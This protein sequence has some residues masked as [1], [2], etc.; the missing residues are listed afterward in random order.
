MDFLDYF[1][2][3]SYFFVVFS[4]ILW[5]TVYLSNRKKLI[6]KPKNIKRAITFLLPSYNEEKNI[7]RCITSI[8]NLN[9]PQN[10]IKIIVIDDGST[11]NT[12]KEASK[13]K[14]VMVIRKKNGGKSTALNEGLKHV[15]TD[16]VGCL[17]GDSFFDPNYLEKMFDKFKGNVGAVTPALKAHNDDSYIRKIQYVEYM[18]SIFLR[19]MFSIFECQYVTPGPGSIYKTDILKNLGGFDEKNMTED[20]EM[21]FRIINSGYK[22]E[23]VMDAYVYTDTPK[24]IGGLF[25]QRIRWYRGYIE[26]TKKYSN[27]IGNKNFGNLGVF[28]LPINFMWMFILSFFLITSMIVLSYNVVQGL[29]NWGVINYGIIMP[30]INE[31]N[32][33]NFYT[34]FNVIFLIIGLATMWL[35][36]KCSGEDVD[37]KKIQH[38]LVYLFIYP[39][40]ISFFWLIS[41]IYEIL[42]VDWKW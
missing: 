25:K 37:I 29:A 5:F 12:F 40:L 39:I 13:F 2:I 22:L 18:F 30:T 36:I 17:D 1:N 7:A 15:T 24:G 3:F 33:V 21:A 32:I 34:F 8:K 27:M 23:N 26:N 28:M 38:Y 16:F 41:V 9:Y 10:L 11:D 6:D 19:K 42:G 4:A 14:D 31:I 20:M 35:G